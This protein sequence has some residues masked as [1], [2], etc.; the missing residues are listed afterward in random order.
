MELHIGVSKIKK[1]ATSE[2]GDTLEF[3]ERP[4]GGMSVV[5][6]DGQ[7]SGKSAKRISN[8]V[9][10]KVISLLAEGIRDGAAAR[11][12]SDFLYHERGGKVMSTLNILSVDLISNT[13]VITRNNPAPVMIA[14][15]GKIDV[16]ADP[17]PPIGVRLNTRPV[18]SEIPLEA[19]LTVLVFTDGITNA[20]ERYGTPMDVRAYFQALLGEENATAQSI[21]DGLLGKAVSLD[22]DRPLDDVSVVV[23][24]VC[25]RKGDNVR[26]VSLY[27]PIGP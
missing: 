23:L 14:R 12:V 15:Y 26:R 20:G 8:K 3:I 11:A 24:Q 27:L 1:Y 7:R 16:L 18:I 21:A 5:L 10:G 13:L 19:G 4:G 17:C 2:S 22:K 9:V 6:A 25:D